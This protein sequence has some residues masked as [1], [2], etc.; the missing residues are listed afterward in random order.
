MPAAK[1]NTAT[2]AQAKTEIARDGCDVIIKKL[3]LDR[4][5]LFATGK[6]I[7][8]RLLILKREPKPKEKGSHMATP[9]G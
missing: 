4:G 6:T 8:V 1:V 9:F 3:F 7:Q 2:K 5:G